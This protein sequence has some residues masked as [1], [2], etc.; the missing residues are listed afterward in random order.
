MSNKIQIDGEIRDM[1]AKEILALEEWRERAQS[2][3]AANETKNANR[4]SAL[5][6]L[7]ALG[8][9]PAEITALVGA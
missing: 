1:N 3:I 2:D 7:E 4:A 9:T 8:L 5:A 6:K